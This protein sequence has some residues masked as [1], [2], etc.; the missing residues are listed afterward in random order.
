MVLHVKFN[1][2]FFH[3]FIIF[4]A[5]L[6]ITFEF[7]LIILILVV[8]LSYNKNCTIC[9]RSSIHTRLFKFFYIWSCLVRHFYYKKIYNEFIKK[10]KY[11]IFGNKKSKIEKFLYFSVS[12]IKFLSYIRLLLIFYLI[13]NI[14]FDWKIAIL[15][16]IFY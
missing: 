16:W 5:T 15:C 9:L 13:K 12:F 11:K 10:L 2:S 8:N 3:I 7:G 1:V 6:H 14:L 4:V